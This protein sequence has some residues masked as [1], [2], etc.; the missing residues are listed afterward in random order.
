M[1]HRI[2]Y[3]FRRLLAILSIQDSFRYFLACLVHLPKFFRRKELDLIPADRTVKRSITVNYKGVKVTVNC[4]R[5]DVLLGEESP[6]FSRARE[7][8]A[9]DVYLKPFVLSRIPFH[10]VIDAGGNCGLFTIFAA[11]L[12]ARVIWLE[13]QETKYQPALAVLRE[14]NHPKGE[15][16]QVGGLLVGSTEKC[17]LQSGVMHSLPK[18]ETVREILRY[19]GRGAVV[20]MRDLLDT[21]VNERVSFLK[22]DIEGY[23]FSVMQDADDWIQQVDNIA[24][25]VHRDAGDPREIVEALERNTFRVVTA[26]SELRPT[27]AATADY[28]Y[29]SATGALR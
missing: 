16:I 14:S 24:L 6:I 29:A 7:M 23:E 4:P 13:V 9:K 25:E 5:I 18:S 28:I 27:S 19:V 17:H 2:A 20:T 8:Y 1:V 11:Q 22:M 12:A 3:R 10:V 15:I 26:D 21:Y